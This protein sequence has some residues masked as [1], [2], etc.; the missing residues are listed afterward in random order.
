MIKQMEAD[1]VAGLA[2]LQ[3]HPS[4]DSLAKSSPSGHI[5]TS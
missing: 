3:A 5:A 4:I 2:H 1:Y